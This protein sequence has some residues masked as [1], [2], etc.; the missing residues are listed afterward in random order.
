MKV[1]TT[2]DS[3]LSLRVGFQALAELGFQQGY[4]SLSPVVVQN[5]GVWHEVIF[6]IT[7]TDLGLLESA[8]SFHSLTSSWR[9]ES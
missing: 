7:S 4:V 3:A 2:S 9:F 5:D 1:E 6:P 8:M